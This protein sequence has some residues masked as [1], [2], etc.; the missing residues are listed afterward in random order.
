[1][2]NF[3][4]VCFRRFPRDAWAGSPCSPICTSQFSIFAPH[5]PSAPRTL[6]KKN[7]RNEPNSI[8]TYFTTMRR[9]SL[10]PP[11]D[12]AIVVRD[13]RG[14]CHAQEQPGLDNAR[15]AFQRLLQG[16]GVVDLSEA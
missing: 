5:A 9:P 3:A 2:G 12:D 7:M 6:R 15:A 14:R 16:W 10:P 1:M 8:I 11:L 4:H 13:Q